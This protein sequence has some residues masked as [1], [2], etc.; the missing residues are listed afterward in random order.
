MG[1]ATYVADP[2]PVVRLDP[3]LAEVAK[4]L[5]SSNLPSANTD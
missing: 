5:E 2:I 4:A 1:A 3:T